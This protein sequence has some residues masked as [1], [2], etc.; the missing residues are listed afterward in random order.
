MATEEIIQF[1]LN[2][3]FKGW[4]L[5]VKITFLAFSAFFL[6]FIIWALIKTT[7][8]KRIFL[9]DLIEFLTFRPLEKQRWIKEWEKI[10]KRL[11]SNLEAEAK[12]AIIEADDLLNEILKNLGYREEDLEKKLNKLSPDLLTNLQ[13]VRQ[14]HK[15][16]DDIV[17]DPSYKL[18]LKEAKKILAIYE[19]AL[20]N[21]E[22]F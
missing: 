11:Q 20:T 17:H 5:A 19:R 6:G 1:I 9:W 18:D 21:L 10:K 7:W 15:V 2:P 22:V 3:T 14:A 4:L 16:R 8:L 12:L 13:E